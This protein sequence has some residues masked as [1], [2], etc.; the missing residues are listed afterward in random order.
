MA[1]YRYSPA[2]S[3]HGPEEI[4]PTTIPVPDEWRA[5][6]LAA[7]ETPG[8]VAL[9]DAA[10]HRLV[11]ALAR[12][13]LGGLPEDLSP[14]AMVALLDAAWDRE[15]PWRE[16]VEERLRPYGRPHR[17][18]QHYLDEFQDGWNRGW[19]SRHGD[20]MAWLTDGTITDEMVQQ[21]EDWMHEQAARELRSQANPGRLSVE[22]LAQLTHAAILQVARHPGDSWTED[23][24]EDVL[25]LVEAQVAAVPPRPE[26]GDPDATPAGVVDDMAYEYLVAR[27]NWGWPAGRASAWAVGQVIDRYRTLASA[28]L[29]RQHSDSAL[30][31]RVEQQF[32]TRARVSRTAWDN[33]GTPPWLRSDVGWLLAAR[34]PRTITPE[35]AE[36]ARV[37]TTPELHTWIDQAQVLEQRPLGLE[38]AVAHDVVD[39]TSSHRDDALVALRGLQRQL[40]QTGPR[41]RPG[42]WSRRA[43]LHTRITEQEQVVRALD[44]LLGRAEKRLG[45]LR[46][47]EQAA[48]RDWQA[49]QDR[50]IGRA[51]AAAGELQLRE[52]GPNRALREPRGSR[53]RLAARAR[54]TSCELAEARL[55]RRRSDRVG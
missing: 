33:P 19:M 54:L 15:Q 17:D 27:R 38:F 45:D 5:G 44:E 16:L 12:R 20:S 48:V 2:P 10:L 26:A 51:V 11:D 34:P 39:R 47:T 24:A 3:G 13:R 50:T 4:D 40:Q 53:R 23:I 49:R 29:A 37:A 31:A 46:P 35:L 28:D 22:Q 55:E 18:L 25:P 36:Q 1:R 21:W 6:P 14:Y 7:G 32:A 43:H 8:R 30:A 9:T 52:Q 42:T 41:W